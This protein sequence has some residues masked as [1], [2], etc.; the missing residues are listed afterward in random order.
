[1]GVDGWFKCGGGS[2]TLFFPIGSREDGAAIT[3]GE[4]ANPRVKRVKE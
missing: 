3:A 4:N 2:T 1:M